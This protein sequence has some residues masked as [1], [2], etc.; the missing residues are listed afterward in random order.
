MTTRKHAPHKRVLVSGIRFISGFTTKAPIMSHADALRKEVAFAL[1]RQAGKDSAAIDGDGDSVVKPAF[2]KGRV[3]LAW[4]R[5]IAELRGPHLVES[6]TG[7]T[8]VVE[9]ISLLE[10]HRWVTDMVRRA[11]S[12][13]VPPDDAV[14]F[15][16]NLLESKYSIIAKY[17]F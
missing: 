9:G 5:C 7:R 3:P 16:F 17:F 13:F 14:G 6:A 15:G 12:D 1:T 8:R 11:D 10:F 4:Y 2:F